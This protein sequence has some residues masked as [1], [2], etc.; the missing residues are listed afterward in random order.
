MTDSAFMTIITKDPMVRAALLE[1]LQI[2]LKVS[3]ENEEYESA[4][5]YRDLIKHLRVKYELKP[6]DKTG[7]DA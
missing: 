1:A 6:E 7:G 3:A 5:Q 4:C 2:G